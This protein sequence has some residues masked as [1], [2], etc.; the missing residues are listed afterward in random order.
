MI[1]IILVCVV[2]GGYYAKN[3][4]MKQLESIAA[5]SHATAAARIGPLEIT[6]NGS[7]PILPHEKTTVRSSATGTVGQ[8]LV[9]EGQYVREGQLVMVISNDQVLQML[10]QSRVE[11]ASQRLRLS[12][13]R[14][15]SDV[16]KMAAETK[17]RQAENALEQ[18]VKDVARLS[19]SSPAAGR[20][21]SVR[22]HP[23]DALTPAQLLLTVVDDTEVYVSASVSQSDIS[24]IRV[25]QAAVVSFGTDLP[26]ATGVVA[27]IAVEAKGS[28]NNNKV[29]VEIRVAN[30]TGLYRVGMVANATIDT[31]SEKVQASGSVTPKARHDVRAEVGGHV[32]SVLVRENDSVKAGQTLIDISNDTLLVLKSQAESDL[33]L[34]R[35]QRDRVS[36]GIVPNVSESDIKQQELRVQQ[37]EI[38]VQARLTEAGYLEVRAPM[39]GVIT[40][41]HVQKADLVSFGALLFTI[42]D[43]DAMSM[44]IPVDE[45]DIANVTLGQPASIKVEALGGRMLTGKVTKIASEGTVKDGVTAYDVTI[46]VE[47]APGLKGAMTGSARIVI[48]SKKEALIVPSEAIR[49]QGDD[50]KVIVLRDNKTVT[51]PVKIGLTGSVLTEVISGLEPGDLVVL[52]SLDRQGMNPF[53]PPK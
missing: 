23:G 31:G 12:T 29:P 41:W 47:P 46:A 19:V 42:A 32:K 26:T 9:G 49:R 7:A 37:A 15:P 43:F 14:A 44:V 27:S 16:D 33:A 25:G 35:E 5:A 2:T 6:V 3:R 48:A 11:L 24:S 39:N 34:A 22:V 13:M 8:I 40:K 20:V 18:R 10:E 52:S 21:S 28:P 30:P 53:A 38:A 50:I 17:L 51:V 4:A 36:S 45:L 1:G